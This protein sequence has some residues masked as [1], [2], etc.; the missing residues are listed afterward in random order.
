[1][2]RLRL[3]PSLLLA[4]ALALA[5]ALGATA[6]ERPSGF[7]ADEVRALERGELVRREMSL[8]ESGGRL[9]GGASFQRVRAPVETVWVKAKD[10]RAL[11]DLI[12]SLDRVRVVEDRGSSRVLYMHHGYAIGET[13]YYVRMD[14]DDRARSLTFQLDTS[15]PHD[16]R[17]GRG[18][19]K[20]SPYR[21]GAIVSWG[22]LMDPGG[23]LVLDAFGPTLNGWLLRPPSCMRDAVEPGREP[24]C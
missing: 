8:R 24:S 3:L 11:T 13:A 9:F 4:S 19:L 12:P 21:G 20:V 18:F 6:Q 5:V 14:F 15:R 10:A 2:S 22:M 23:G 16:I 7:T 17:A 1:M